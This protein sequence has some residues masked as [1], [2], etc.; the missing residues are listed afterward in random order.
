[1]SFLMLYSIISFGQF[2]SKVHYVE[3]K[4]GGSISGKPIKEYDTNSN[5]KPDKF[6]KIVL[7]PDIEFQTI[8]GIGG[9]FNEIG[10]Q[11]LMSLPMALQEEVS[12]NLFSPDV[13]GFTYCRTA[14]GASDFGIDAYSYSEVAKDYD[15]KYF[16]ID[17]EGK[18]VIP[19][20]KQALK[21]NPSLKIF[22]SPWSPPGWMKYSGLMDK[23]ID[24]PEK[25]KL[26]DDPKIYSSYA[27]Y[28]SKYIQAYKK[29]GIPISRLCIQNEND[30]NTNYPSNDMPAAEMSAFIKNYLL[31]A[32]DKAKIDTEIW[33]GTFRT[34]SKIDAIEFVANKENHSLVKGIGIQYTTPTYI[35]QMTALYPEVK[36][37]HTEG[38]CFGGK[39]SIKEAF[40][41]L[42]EIANYI[43]YG[44]QNYCYWNMILNETGKSGWDWKQ[45]SLINID[46]KTNE[47]IY[48]PDYS[49]MMLISKYL[50]PGVIRIAH[51]SRA[52][53]ISVKQGNKIFLFIQNET[54]VAKSYDCQIN[55][56][57]IS[58]VE[59]PPSS[60]A[61]IELT[62][63]TK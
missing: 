24:F 17:R 10:G 12:R 58:I 43:N 30:A 9:A 37:M 44:S 23:G 39:N 22:A 21:Y 11:A 41:R 18:T 6:S 60:V 54:E 29:L 49:V 45:N 61:V 50:K 14:V 33:A 25:N 8:E 59:I 28:F 57:A 47:I 35:Q 48:N 27:L 13:G 15:M 31:K 40:S 38:N 4:E 20:I 63:M 56:K 16:S 32:F 55:D 34:F 52:N 53:L 2:S 3:L 1:M 62:S 51:Y 46:L 7:Y 26:I 36:F 5:I 19:Y 42:E